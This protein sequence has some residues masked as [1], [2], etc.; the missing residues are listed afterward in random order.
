MSKFYYTAEP[1]SGCFGSDTDLEIVGFGD[2]IIG[3]GDEVI[4]SKSG[5]F[6]RSPVTQTTFHTATAVAAAFPPVGTVAAG[7]AEAAWAIAGLFVGAGEERAAKRKQK[8]EAMRAK[9]AAQLAE[10]KKRGID[11]KALVE[12]AK[13]AGNLFAQVKAMPGIV[14]GQRKAEEAFADVLLKAK[15]GDR[16]AQLVVIGT[17]LLRDPDVKKAHLA[18]KALAKGELPLKE[19][20]WNPKIASEASANWEQFKAEALKI[21]KSKGLDKIASKNV[22]PIGEVVAKAKSKGRA[23]AKTQLQAAKAIPR[24]AGLLVLR[25]G[26][27]VRGTFAKV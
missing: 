24:S 18:S 8:R 4:G 19:E 3:W 26:A 25:S 13:K 15:S 17:Q 9:H 1:I 14:G 10:L 7:A 12:R 20:L 21:A 5:D 23:V 27:I 16:D 2:E 22:L 11:P 6:M